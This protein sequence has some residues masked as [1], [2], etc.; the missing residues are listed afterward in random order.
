M[1]RLKSSPEGILWMPVTSFTSAERTCF[2]DAA[3]SERQYETKNCSNAA[4]E[5]TKMTLAIIGAPRRAGRARCAHLPELAKKHKP[6]TWEENSRKGVS[7]TQGTCCGCDK[8]FARRNSQR[9]S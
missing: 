5:K 2:E 9:T 4:A 8:G 7:G 1:T 6:K 3:M